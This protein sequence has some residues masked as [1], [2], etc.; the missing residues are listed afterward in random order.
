[1]T[2][3]PTIT[4]VAAMAKN[5]VIGYQN[6]MPWHMPADLKHFKAI[7]LGKPVVMGRKTYDSIGRPLPGRRNIVISR[8]IDLQIDGCEV[9]HSLDEALSTL[10]GAK[11]IMI[12]G[13]GTLYEMTLPQADRLCLTLI[14]CECDGDAFFPAWDK[15]EWHL[16]SDVAH[17][18]DAQNPHA[19]RF[20]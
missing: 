12:I 18:A 15:Q 10:A 14:D 17:D 16:E 6:Q 4:L 19:Y 5:R 2:T 20:Y 9:V 3:T 11:E 1:M 13:G 8:Q 7:T